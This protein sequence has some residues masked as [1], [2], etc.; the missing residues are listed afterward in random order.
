MGRPKNDDLPCR[1]E[2][3]ANKRQRCGDVRTGWKPLGHA[4]CTVPWTQTPTVVLRLL[5][6]CGRSTRIDGRRGGMPMRR[7][8]CVATGHRR[9]N[10]IVLGTR[11]D[12]PGPEEYRDQ[13]ELEHDCQRSEPTRASHLHE[14]RCCR[15]RRHHGYEAFNTP[16][17]TGGDF[18]T[19][20][21]RR[22]SRRA[23]RPY[24]RRTPGA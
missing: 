16:E 17:W 24:R 14:F 3:G 22:T 5:V 13:P 19:V 10:T 7:T 11:V 23:R 4:A 18:T 20:F 21:Y 9:W 8:A 12:N 1:A 6:G 2:R 15:S